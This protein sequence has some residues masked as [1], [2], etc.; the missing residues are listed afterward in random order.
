MKCNNCILFH[1]S[2]ETGLIGRHF[3]LFNRQYLQI[4][5][6]L[7]DFFGRFSGHTVENKIK[8]HDKA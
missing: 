5:V 6:K 8:S 3:N 1:I 2:I 7:R 4:S